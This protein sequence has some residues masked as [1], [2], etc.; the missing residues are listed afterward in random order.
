MSASAKSKKSASPDFPL[1]SP[2]RMAASYAE[3][4]LMAWSKIVGFDVSPVTENSSLY[5]LSVPLS[6]RSRVMLSSQMLWPRLWSNCVAFNVSPPSCGPL[7]M[8]ASLSHR[9]DGRKCACDL[10]F[11]ADV[12]N[13][14]YALL[15]LGYYC[16]HGLF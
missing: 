15:C 4:F 7:F 13:A 1:A 12:E 3:L 9:R 6:R 16:G 14:V 10:F 8:R 11:V 2:S 5:C